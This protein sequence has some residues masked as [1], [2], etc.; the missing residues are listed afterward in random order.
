M[1]EVDVPEAIVAPAK[2]MTVPVVRI[3]VLIPDSF[4]SGQPSPSES[5]SW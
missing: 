2:L 1:V 4:A 3:D 5:K